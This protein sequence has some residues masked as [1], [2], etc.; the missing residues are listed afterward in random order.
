MTCYDGCYKDLNDH[1][2]GMLNI[3]DGVCKSKCPE[4]YEEDN[5]EKV[6][7]LAPCIRRNNTNKDGHVN[8]IAPNYPCLSDW[9]I[10]FVFVYF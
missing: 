5:Y 8:P 4:H 9:F 10:P 6:C 2:V 3:W 7:V 1:G